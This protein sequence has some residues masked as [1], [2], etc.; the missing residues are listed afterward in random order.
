MF[1][2]KH[3]PSS[4]SNF[5]MKRFLSKT[6]LF[7]VIFIS[8]A[9]I[10]Q[11]IIDRGLR[12]YDNDMYINWNR[13]FRGQ[14]NSDI[15]I[16][17]SSRATQHFN[18]KIIEKQVGFSCYNLGIVAGT[19]ILEE[20]KWETSLRY[21]KTPKILIQ[22]V[23][24]FFLC[25]G[26]KIAFKEQFLPYLAEPTI[27]QNLVKIDDGIIVENII[28]LYKYRG[29]REIVFQG[30]GSFFNLIKKPVPAL[31]DFYKGYYS[32]IEKWNGDFEKFNVKNNRLEFSWQEMQLGINY[33]ESLI[34]RCEE[35][36]IEII[37]V[38][39]PMYYELQN[40]M[41][42]KDSITSLFSGVAIK[43]SIQ[44][45]NYLDDSLCYN[46]E[47]FYNST[48]LNAIGAEIFSKHLALDINNFIDKNPN[49]FRISD[50][51]N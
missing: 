19:I 32:L 1:K 35:R 22:N 11:I 14:I 9:F 16:L 15:V 8:L 36:N 3:H 40:M 44:F 48:H 17:G 46:K 18:P 43:N 28:P 41:P 39:S 7:V 29:L 42:Q 30:L 34:K 49:K 47:Y 13:I 45:W 6:F 37:L 38:Q 2:T 26:E 4:I 10:L 12:N 21:N 5:D 24:I 25:P 50:D 33:L 20:A 27:Y 51:P 23:D 31:N